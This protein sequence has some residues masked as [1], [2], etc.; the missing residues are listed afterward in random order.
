[1]NIINNFGF[2]DGTSIHSMDLDQ[3]ILTLEMAI[4]QEHINVAGTLDEGLV[5]TLADNH[6]SY[7]LMS[8]SLIRN[9]GGMP[10][11]VS[12]SLNVQALAPIEP[13][14]K[15]HVVCRVGNANLAKLHV[16]V[17]FVDAERPSVVYA[18]ASHTKH[19]KDI[20]GF[21]NFKAAKM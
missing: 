13:N 4:T 16:T 14:T 1:M 2:D 8:H 20:L 11:S 17:M 9:P 7:L 21:A 12:L 5:A 15:V 3:G 6:T 10:I 19:S 18:W